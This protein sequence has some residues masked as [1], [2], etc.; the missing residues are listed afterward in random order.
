MKIF[1]LT[2]FLRQ[3]RTYRNLVRELSSYSDYELQ[4]IGI[5]RAGIHEIA[6]RMSQEQ[7]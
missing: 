1:S 7:Q 6:R 2:R 3:R 5:D 4:D